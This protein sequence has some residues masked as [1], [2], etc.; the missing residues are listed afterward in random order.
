MKSMRKMLFAVCAAGCVLMGSA[1][2]AITYVD[3]EP[4]NTTLNG[5]PLVLEVNYSLDYVNVTDNLWGWRT[6][7]TDVNGAGIWVT[8]GGGDHGDLDRE[9]TAPLKIDIILPDVGIYDLYAVIMNNNTGT[10][11]WDVAA[12][13]GDTGEFTNYNK[14]SAAMTLA[15][16]AD[17]DSAVNISTATSGDQTFKVL[18]G[19]YTA[20]TANETVSIYIN[21]LDSWGVVN[22]DQRTRF[23]G[24]GYEWV[25]VPEPA[26]M[27]LLSAG[28]F[29]G[30]RR[31]K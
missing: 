12:R 19:Q 26:T 7:R 31:R 28:A 17:F 25:T 15:V 5:D 6:N 13:I 22:L 2:G 1:V 21:G 30:L 24:V 16:A 14:N 23:D 10:G 11:Y 29:F 4:G 18:I 9:S 20:A 8:D 3:A 27:L